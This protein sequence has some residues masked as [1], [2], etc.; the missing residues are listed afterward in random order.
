M[1][2]AI[3]YLLGVMSLLAAVRPLQ[4]QGRDVAT[5]PTAATATLSGIV[6]NDEEPPQPVR[7]AIVTLT[8]DGL[9]HS[10]SAVSDDDG[11]FIL[12]GLPPGRF[13]LT[14]M[15]ASYVTS[16]FGAKRPGRPG[17][18]IT[19]TN[20]STINGV[21][22]RLWR[23]AVTAGIVRDENGFPVQGV[24]V[25]A[26]RQ[27]PQ[28]G[29]VAAAITL[30][31]NGI[32]TNEAGEFRIFGLEPGPYLISAKPPGTGRGALTAPSEAQID[33][34]LKALSLRVPGSKPP[35]GMSPP[36]AQTFEFAPVYYPGTASI[37]QAVGVVLVAGEERTGVDV[38]L[39]R[40]PAVTVEGRVTRQDGAP[41]ARAAVQL[42]RVLRG[43]SAVTAEPETVNT[44]ADDE[45]MFRIAQVTPGEY[46]VVARASGARLQATPGVEGT[47][48]PVSGAAPSLWARADVAVSGTPVTGLVLTMEPGLQLSGSVI[49]RSTASVPPGRP[50]FAK[51][52]VALVS[53]GIPNLTAGTPPMP[54]GS[55]I[56]G[57]VQPDGSFR[58]SNV[59]PDTYRLLVTGLGVSAYWV[60]QSAMLGDRDL[61]DMPVEVTRAVSGASITISFSDRPAELTGRLQT[62]AGEPASDVFIVAFALDRKFWIGE[63]R[64]VQAMRP[65]IDGTF[66]FMSL[67]PGDYLLGAVSDVDDGE[68]YDPAFLEAL[69]SSSVKVSLVEGQRKVQHLQLRAK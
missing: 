41:V 59:V 21:I 11:R 16:S 4:G 25:T 22:V 33:A 13:T 60:A 7:R 30:T 34:E 43:R 54:M 55:W 45:G 15:R 67:P 62:Q 2:S 20:G 42:A 50:D 18:A 56:D 39:Q 69:I 44:T 40:V 27:K 8:G 24:S 65:A 14:A 53:T 38:S 1:K 35:S 9:R 10:R 49:F 47:V 63:T 26:I 3:S 6:V 36:P 12:S 32:A 31:N 61:F 5:V 57:Y 37:D 23:G 68:W 66:T 58:F 19:V 29:R 46:K 52:R 28:G 17:I 48:P 64:R 51:L